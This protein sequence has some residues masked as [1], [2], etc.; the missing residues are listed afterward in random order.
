M[1]YRLRFSTACVR[2]MEGVLGYTLAHFGQRSHEKYKKLI[3]QALLEIAINPDNPRAKPRPEIRENV[4]TYHIARRGKRARHF[5][6]YRVL[7]DHFVEIGRF[8]HD[9]MDLQQHLPEG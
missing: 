9:A 2:D 8:L 6:L 1:R 3:R 4:R 5:F 7:N